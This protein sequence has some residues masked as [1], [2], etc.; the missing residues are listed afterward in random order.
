[1]IT[2]NLEYED[3]VNLKDT[4]DEILL[5]T[6]TNLEQMYELTP[7]AIAVTKALREGAGNE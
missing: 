7:I 6:D 1:M 3:A 5:C 4:L 2:V